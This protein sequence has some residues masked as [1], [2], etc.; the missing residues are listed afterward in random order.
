M[1]DANVPD[2]LK[3]AELKELLQTETGLKENLIEIHCMGPHA[4]R[5]PFCIVMM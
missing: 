5:S 2:Q 3:T 4:H 1:T